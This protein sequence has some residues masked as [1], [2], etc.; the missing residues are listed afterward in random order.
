MA[1]AV[2]AVLWADPAFAEIVC[3][4]TPSCPHR[5][6]Q[7]LPSFSLRAITSV[8]GVKPCCPR[9]STPA[10]TPECCVSAET[11]AVLPV[12]SFS[13]ANSGLQPALAH[14]PSA[15]FSCATLTGGSLLLQFEAAVAYVKPVAQKKTDLRI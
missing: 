13:S 10:E 9:H 5:A 11:G 4:A 7:T 6:V 14:S 3:A 8:S 12:A 15:L 1:L 2:W